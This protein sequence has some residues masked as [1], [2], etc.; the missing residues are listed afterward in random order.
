MALIRRLV[1]IGLAEVGHGLENPVLVRGIEIDVVRIL[2]E[3]IDV[4]RAHIALH[5]IEQQSIRHVIE[6][7]A[8]LEIF[9]QLAAIGQANAPGDQRIGMADGGQAAEY[10]NRDRD[11]Q[12]SHDLSPCRTACYPRPATF[13]INRCVSRGATSPVQTT[14][15]SGRTNVSCASYAAR[16]SA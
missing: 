10:E 7:F 12:S 2:V 11:V 6:P 13:A 15:W 9:D 1:G 5:P 16:P 3:Q 4:G 8:R 14:Y